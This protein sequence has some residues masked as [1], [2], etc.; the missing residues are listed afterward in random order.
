MHQRI[1]L[2]ETEIY[3]DMHLGLKRNT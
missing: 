2:L 1:I 3:H